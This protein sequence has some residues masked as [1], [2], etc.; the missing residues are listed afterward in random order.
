M[1]RFLLI[2]QIGLVLFTPG[3]ATMPDITSSDIV[4]TEAQH[5]TDSTKEQRATLVG[6]WYRKQQTTDGGTV[7]ELTVMRV[8]GSYLFSFRQT[9]V[10]G[11]SEDYFESGLWGISGG[12]HFTFSI[13]EGSSRESMYRVDSTN[14][15]NYL[16]YKVLELNNSKFRYQTVATGNI[17]ELQR[18]DDNFEFPK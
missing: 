8:D 13:A 14:H 1:H 15:K 3:C 10:A 4:D 16:V 6:S 2:L 7:E 5:H 18:V 12:Y 9:D 17:Y 11:H